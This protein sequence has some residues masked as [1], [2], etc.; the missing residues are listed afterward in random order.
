MGSSGSEAAAGADS[1]LALLASLR[2]PRLLVAILAATTALTALGAVEY[3]GRHWRGGPVSF[4]TMMFAQAIGGV[5]WFVLVPI[6]VAP[7]AR[8]FP[9]RRDGFGLAAAIQTGLALLVAALHTFAVAVLFASYYYGYAPRA[10]RDVFL[11]RMHSWYGM[12]VL[13]YL[14][15]VGMMSLRTAPS[16]RSEPDPKAGG[17]PVRRLLVKGEGRTMILPV[18]QVEWIEAADNNVLVHT[19]DTTHVVR[20][21]LTAMAA[22]LNPRQFVRIHRSSL[23]NLEAVRELQPWFHGELVVILKD[24]TRLTV[25]RTYRDAFLAALGG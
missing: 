17:R 13:I 21:P 15:I 2:A 12:S 24:R 16:A 4:D 9:L 11:D 22:R 6:V 23:V 20:H 18:D 8:R 25:G 5:L 3:L 7:L 19:A 1:R 10:I 14:L